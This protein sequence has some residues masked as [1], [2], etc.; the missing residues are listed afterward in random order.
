MPRVA[1][2]CAKELGGTPPSPL[3]HP[4]AG[5]G[6]HFFGVP[7]DGGTSRQWNDEVS[8]DAKM[9][10]GALDEYFGEGVAVSERILKR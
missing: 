10:Y 6:R 2:H 4:R 9:P 3:L 5:E 7:F 1:R 8:K